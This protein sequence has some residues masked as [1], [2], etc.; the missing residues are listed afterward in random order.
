M[1]GSEAPFGGGPFWWG[2]GGG[3]GGGGARGRGWMGSAK[4]SG[5]LFHDIYYP[6]RELMF[7]YV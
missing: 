5:N 4:S 7:S 6:S 1:G 3:G 2:G